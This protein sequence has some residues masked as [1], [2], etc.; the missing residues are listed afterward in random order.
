M[1]RIFSLGSPLSFCSLNKNQT[2]G[3]SV[4]EIY[5]ACKCKTC[6]NKM[7]YDALPLKKNI[8]AFMAGGFELI[9]HFS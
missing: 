6:T 8:V 7:R 3:F 5:H 2:S 9:S 4:H 1:Q